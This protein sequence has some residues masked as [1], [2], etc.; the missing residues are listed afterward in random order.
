LG[1]LNAVE[2]PTQYNDA[3][4][5]LRALDAGF[6]H[7][8]IGSLSAYHEPGKS[9]ARTRAIV[10]AIHDKIR[11]KHPKMDKYHR[12]SPSLTKFT[13]DIL[14]ISLNAP[15]FLKIASFYRRLYKKLNLT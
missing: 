7:I 13:S 6:R 8:Y 11:S 14:S 3:D 15:A 10:E 4:Y 5:C 1:G 9:E 2:F 12:I